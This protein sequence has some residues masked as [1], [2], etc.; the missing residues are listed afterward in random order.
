MK[1]VV[2]LAIAFTW[3]VSCKNNDQSADTAY[4]GI[5]AVDIENLEVKE[6]IAVGRVEPAGGIVDLASASGGI[7]DDIFREGGET[8]H[9]GEALIRLDNELEQIRIEQIKSQI[10]SQQV[11]LEVEQLNL[12]DTEARMQNKSRLLASARIL[13]GKGA[14]T[15]QYLDDLETEVQ[16]LQV[17]LEKARAS[18]RL[19][20]HKLEEMNQQLALAVAESEKK[21]IRSPYE[22]ILLDVKV[23]RGSAVG[24]FQQVAEL[25]PAGRP[26]IRAEVDEL[27]AGRLR[28]GQQAIIRNVGGTSAVATGKVLYLSPYLKRKSLFSGQTGEQEDRLVREITISLDDSA[29]ILLNAKVE[30]S[31]DLQ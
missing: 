1:R 15:Q 6:I 24:A 5:Q 28:T 31:I 8:V 20:G 9:K 21:T 30:C 4:G 18:L 11:Q 22:G 16:S 12:G 23:K 19:A 2:F 17:E 26:V 25:A 27:F 10:R 14:E 29:D 13:A 3:L 7:I